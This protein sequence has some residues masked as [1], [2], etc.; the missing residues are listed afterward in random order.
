MIPLDLDAPETGHLVDAWL[1][2]WRRT[3]VHP[4]MGCG[5]LAACSGSRV[6]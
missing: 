1:V 3:G 6:A 5:G 2:T 4:R